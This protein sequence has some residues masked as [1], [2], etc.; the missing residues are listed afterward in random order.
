MVIAVVIIV[1]AIAVVI[2]VVIVVVIA[3]VSI[4][5]IVVIVVADSCPLRY[6]GPSLTVVRYAGPRLRAAS[7]EIPLPVVY[8]KMRSFFQPG[9][10]GDWTRTMEM[11]S[12]DLKF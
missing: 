5:D 10:L 8:G 4:I 7:R 1:V 6:A 2:I 3:V 9:C 12:Y 11:N